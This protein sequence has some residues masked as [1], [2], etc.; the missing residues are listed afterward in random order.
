MLKY[1]QIII[2]IIMPF[3]NHHQHHHHHHYDNDC[4]NALVLFYKLEFCLTQT[5]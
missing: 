3:Q 2:I 5:D 4:L 1:Y